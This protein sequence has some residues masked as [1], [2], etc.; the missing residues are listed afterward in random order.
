MIHVREGLYHREMFVFFRN[1]QRILARQAMAS[2]CKQLLSAEIF[3]LQM[4]YKK[5]RNHMYFRAA[6]RFLSQ[7]STSNWILCIWPHSAVKYLR[8]AN[9]VMSEK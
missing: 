6:S 8:Y 2:I 1:I 9:M 7:S 3:F 4:Q 5:L